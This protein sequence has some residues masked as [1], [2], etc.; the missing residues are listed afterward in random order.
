VIALNEVDRLQGRP[1]GALRIVL[2]LDRL[3][4]PAQL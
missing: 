2:L 3:E 4:E 1:C